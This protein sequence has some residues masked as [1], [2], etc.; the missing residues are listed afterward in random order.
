MKK[1]SELYPI[2]TQRDFRNYLVDRL[3]V[4]SE[5]KVKNDQ[6]SLHNYFNFLEEQGLWVHNPTKGSKLMKTK[7]VTMEAPARE[8]VD[9]DLYRCALS[10][11]ASA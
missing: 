4:V 8:H 9:K 5:I 7:K 1:F 2:P 11:P 6:K 10:A 3:K